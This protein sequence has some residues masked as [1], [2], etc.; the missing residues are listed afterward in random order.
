[1]WG[2]GVELVGFKDSR[3]FSSIFKKYIGIT[4]TEYKENSN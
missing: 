1:M 4:P 2:G 3:Y